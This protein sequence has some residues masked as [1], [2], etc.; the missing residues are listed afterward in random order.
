MRQTRTL[1]FTVYA[2]QG[3][4]G[5]LCIGNLRLTPLPPAPSGEPTPAERTP[6]ALL[7][8]QAKRAPRGIYPRGFSGEQSYWT[9][10]GVDGGAKQSALISEDGAVEVRKGGWSIEPMLLDG[11][12]LIDWATVKTSQS[13]QDDYLPIPTAHWQADGLRLETTAFASGAPDAER[14]EERRVG[15]ECRS[16]WSPYH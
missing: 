10:V 16:R 7:Q 13:L 15:K 11:G 12:T 1:E 9:L 6:N 5:E 14:S 3:G 4:R 8:Q 2:G